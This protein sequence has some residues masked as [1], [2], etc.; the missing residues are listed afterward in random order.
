MTLPDSITSIGIS[1]FENCTSLTGISIPSTVDKIASRAF[2]GCTSL[3]GIH[4]PDSLTSINDNIL[5]ETGITAVTVPKNVSSIT[6][7]FMNGSYTV[8]VSNENKH[9]KSIDNMIYSKDGKTL[10]Y[11][12]VEK[13][14]N[15]TLL[16]TITKIDNFAF[17]SCNRVTS[18]VLPSSIT[19]IHKEAFKHCTSLTNITIPNCATSIRQ[20][21]FY[22]CKSLNKIALG[23]GLT[24]L[25]KSI[26]EDYSSLLNVTIP[27]SVSK[28][29]YSFICN[30]QNTMFSI[31]SENKAF[32]SE[33][34]WIMRIW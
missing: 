31:D 6:K 5:Y 17:S 2:Y 12:S 10:I 30:A 14:G 19:S 25:E 27:K 8:K 29:G 24:S 28:I 15:V 34:D 33:N 26:F 32:K 7:F 21:A 23:T 16:N 13:K 18:I 3:R 11:C 1:C 9:F 22:N 4:L 20:N